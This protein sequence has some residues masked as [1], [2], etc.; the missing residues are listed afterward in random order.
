MIRYLHWHQHLCAAGGR[1]ATRNSNRIS[2][3]K[4]LENGPGRTSGGT[5]PQAKLKSLHPT[6]L[7]DAHTSSSGGCSTT[8][9]GS[10]FFLSTTVLLKS[11][12]AVRC[13]G[14]AWLLACCL[15]QLT[16]GGVVVDDDAGVCENFKKISS[17]LIEI[18]LKRG[19]TPA[20]S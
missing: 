15:C 7:H 16:G 2:R 13:A 5:D 4:G 11:A 19:K 1:R 9:H 18:R 6:Q 17:I 3:A 10:P 14:C 12:N 20:G 8:A